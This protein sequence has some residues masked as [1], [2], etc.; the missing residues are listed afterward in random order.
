MP[1]LLSLISWRDLTV[2]LVVEMRLKT[3]SHLILEVQLAV[4]IPRV[5]HTWKHLYV[6]VCLNTHMSC[7]VI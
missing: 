3:M 2:V 4:H 5:T 7:L 1:K 6:Y